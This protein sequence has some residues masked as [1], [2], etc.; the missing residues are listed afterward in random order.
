VDLTKPE[1]LI[2][3]MLADLGR[4]PEAREFDYELISKAMYGGHYWYFDWLDLIG[5]EG[6]LEENKTLVIDTLD[7]FDMIELTVEKIDQSTFEEEA[8][9]RGVEPCWAKFRGFD[10][11][12][13]SELYGI[14]DFL[15][16]DLGRFQRFAGRDLNS[17]VPGSA[18]SYRRM[19]GV[20]LPIRHKFSED[21][22]PLDHLLSVLSAKRHPSA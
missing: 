5:Y 22:L 11:N 2:I 6:N 13:E 7:M 10:G 21:G 15:I 14:A 16:R 17:H 12:N 8:R 4:K 18:D 3:A 9:K 19:L 1:K 20:F